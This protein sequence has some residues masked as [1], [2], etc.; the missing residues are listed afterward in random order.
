MK[1]MY[2]SSSEIKSAPES[3]PGTAMLLVVMDMFSLRAVALDMASDMAYY[4]PFGAQSENAVLCARHVCMACSDAD[5]F[6]QAEEHGLDLFA[7]TANLN[8][9]AWR[10]WC[11]EE[12]ECYRKYSRFGRLADELAGLAHRLHRAGLFESERH[13]MEAASYAREVSA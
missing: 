3:V 9:P 5:V 2:H 7:E 1:S 11:G 8:P 6:E 10:T 12:E 13:V 4:D